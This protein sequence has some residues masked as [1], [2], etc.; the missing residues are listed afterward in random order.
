MDINVAK[1][2]GLQTATHN[3]DIMLVKDG[4]GD[5]EEDPIIV[6]A[7]DSPTSSQPLIDLLG[8]DATSR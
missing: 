1:I 2:E 4:P 6:F 3:K 7:D 8:G 5:E